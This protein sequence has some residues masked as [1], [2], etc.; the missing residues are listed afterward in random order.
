MAAT[1]D[2]WER[3]HQNLERQIL[4]WGGVDPFQAQD[5]VVLNGLLEAHARVRATLDG[6]IPGDALAD[7]VN[8]TDQVVPPSPGSCL[9]DVHYPAIHQAAIQVIEQ[10][11]AFIERTG[12]VHELADAVDIHRTIRA[13]AKRGERG[14]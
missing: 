6:F 9:C 10:A 7:Y 4:D 12:T 14:G 1:R 13:S 8:V 3:I 11:Y 2:D 5:F